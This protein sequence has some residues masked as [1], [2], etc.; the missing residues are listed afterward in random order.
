MKKTMAQIIKQR[1]KL[2]LKEKYMDVFFEILRN[3]EQIIKEEE[4]NK[5]ETI[6]HKYYKD[7]NYH[8]TTK[9]KVDRKRKM[10]ARQNKKK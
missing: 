3:I 4:D 10:L 7:K 6:F 2:F 1:I 9:E 8:P 5:I